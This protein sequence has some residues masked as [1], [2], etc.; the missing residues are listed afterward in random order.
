MKSKF[1]S[2]LTSAVAASVL[3]FAAIGAVNADRGHHYGKQECPVG[4]PYA[5][6]AKNPVSFTAMFGH[7]VEG[8]IRCNKER[9]RVK[10]VVQ[11]N[12]FCRDRHAT[13]GTPITP[14]TCG[15]KRAYALGNMQ[16]MINDY[17][18]T[19]G[20]DDDDF[21]MVAIIHSAGGHLAR[22]M[23]GPGI[24]NPY[25]AQIQSLQDQGV[26]FYFCLNTAAGFIKRNVFKQYAATGIP[27]QD[28]ML[29]GIGFVPAGL[30]S[31]ADFQMRGYTYVQ[32]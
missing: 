19:H 9:K 13:D 10:L 27:L 26:K 22:K 6:P 31:I 21:R 30:N 4:T 15:L 8:S 20:M 12:E 3:M 32:P 2:I 11:V 16:N 14:L 28:Q 1:L 29:P 25:A 23:F 5:D 17:K 24:P 18:K 7:E